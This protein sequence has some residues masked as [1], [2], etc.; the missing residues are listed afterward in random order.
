[1]TGREIIDK[2]EELEIYAEEVGC[3]DME[4]PLPEGIGEWKSVDYGSGDE[5]PYYNVIHFLD[6]DVYLKAD[7]WYASHQGGEYDDLFEVTPK[8]KTITTYS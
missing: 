8:E 2:L 7:G 3:E 1:M 5:S 4:N 6:H